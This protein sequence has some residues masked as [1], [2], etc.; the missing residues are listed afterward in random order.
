MVAPHPS[1]GLGIATEKIV[2]VKSSRA[3]ELQA[4]RACALRNVPE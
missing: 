2:L 3:M 1:V 4:A